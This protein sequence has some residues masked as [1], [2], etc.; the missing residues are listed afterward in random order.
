MNLL[1]LHPNFPGQFK[2]LVKASANLNNETKFLCQTHYG[3]YISGVER[4]TLK[5]D[6]SHE[7]LESQKPTILE[8]SQILATQYRNGLIQIKQS[9]WVPDLVISHSGWGCGLHVKELWPETKFIAYLEWWFNP[10]SSFFHY[11]KS[12][13]FLMINSNS[14]HKSWLRNQHVA[15]E[16]ATADHIVSPTKWQRNQLPKIFREK[17]KTVFDGIDLDVFKPNDNLYK[18]SLNLDK[19]IIITY[20]TRGMDPMRGFPQL[21][22]SLPKLLKTDSRIRMEIAGESS[23]FYGN[24]LAPNGMDWKDWAINLLEKEGITDRVKW[25]GRLNAIEYEQWLQK[26]SCHIYLTHPFIASWSLIEAYCCGTPL[27]VSDV[28]ATREICEGDGASLFIDHREESFL[29]QNVLNKIS[30]FA[31]MNRVSIAA[32]RDRRRFGVSAALRGWERVAGL[33]VN[34]ND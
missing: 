14:I 16:L 32:S 12:N 8:R 26:S 25:V 23:A 1:F 6:S 2:H 27:V 7:A 30:E 29:N 31:K 9:G 34:T 11:D 18:K 21:I 19:E 20:G 4:L 3:R 33:E 15:L 24:N 10:R 22:K 5:K 28:E 17:C 13:K